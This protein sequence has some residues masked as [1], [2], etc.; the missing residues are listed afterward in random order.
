MS[1]D[2][3]SRE[4]AENLVRYF[5][6]IAQENDAEVWQK[7]LSTAQEWL[8]LIDSIN[9]SEEEISSFLGVVHANRHRT[10]G[11]Y[12]LAHG[13][14]SWARFKGY[15]VPLAE[16]FFAPSQLSSI[17]NLSETPSSDQ[18]RELLKTFQQYHLE[19]PSSEAWEAG[20]KLTELWLSLIEAQEVKKSEITP[21]IELANV[22]KYV[23]QEW[24]VAVLRISF[25]CKK[26][27]HA[28]LIPDYFR[29][30]V[31]RDNR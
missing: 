7:G 14:Y 4:H 30:L 19:D 10:S 1:K 5:A 31:D 26:V 25:W 6:R 11:W 13:A 3:E 12:D 29:D 2:S 15:P 27:G 8:R 24:F 28:D 20:I 16:E 18:A 9:C 17:Q 22:Q 23:S 21:L